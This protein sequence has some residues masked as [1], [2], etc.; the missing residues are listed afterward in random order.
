MAIVQCSAERYDQC[1][2]SWVKMQHN[3]EKCK[4]VLDIVVFWSQDFTT[5]DG[6][7]DGLFWH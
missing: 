5:E 4:M 2:I 7:V 6:A 3:F 1:R